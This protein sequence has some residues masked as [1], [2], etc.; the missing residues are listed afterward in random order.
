[1]EFRASNESHGRDIS[2]AE[3][4]RMLRVQA[5]AISA[6][7]ALTIFGL[8]D[9]HAAA[10]LSRQGSQADREKRLNEPRTSPWT[11]G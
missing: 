1:M 7:V 10:S 8:L 2:P 4:S 3:E 9:V 11:I 6:N 5:A